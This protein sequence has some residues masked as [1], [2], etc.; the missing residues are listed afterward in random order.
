M[1]E[2]FIVFSFIPL[3]L[4]H[5]YVWLV[6]WIELFLALGLIL[7]IFLR[8]ISA[9]SIL[10]VFSFLLANFLFAY[11]GFSEQCSNCFGE[12]F[13]LKIFHAI[14]IDLLMLGIAIWIFLRGDIGMSLDHWR[15]RKANLP[16]IGEV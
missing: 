7:G 16:K 13:H 1:A 2:A 4:I 10:V 8:F 14:A 15:L 6:P 5:G 12:L 9:L 3:D 11:Y